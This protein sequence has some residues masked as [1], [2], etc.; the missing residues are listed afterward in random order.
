M[1]S[2]AAPGMSGAT[3]LMRNAA[4]PSGEMSGGN[5]SGTPAAM[6]AAAITSMA[7]SHR[8]SRGRRTPW[9]R[10]PVAT[11]PATISSPP[12][13]PRVITLAQSGSWPGSSRA[14]PKA[15]STPRIVTVAI[16]AL[17]VPNTSRA[18]A[19]H[20]AASSPPSRYRTQPRMAT[21]TAASVA[22]ASMARARRGLTIAGGTPGS[23]STTSVKTASAIGTRAIS[24]SV[25]RLRPSTLTPLPGRT[26][27]R[28]AGA[29]W[30]PAPADPRARASRRSR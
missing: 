20:R 7:G 30:W 9:R 15:V 1:S 21:A 26:P 25:Q 8:T 5:L 17:M 16:R 14:S 29:R 27:S 28:R 11:R 18:D 10:L 24:R 12:A 22:T 13:N 23:T 19:R 4:M 3:R 2:G 6:K